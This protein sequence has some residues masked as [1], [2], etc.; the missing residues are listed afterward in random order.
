MIVPTFK[1]RATLLEAVQSV[2]A[3]TWVDLEI[4]V[5]DDACPDDSTQVLT[6]LSDPRIR[7]VR[8][9]RN[10]GLSGARNAGMSVARG[11]FIALLDADDRCSPKRLERQISVLDA[12]PNVGLVTSLANRIDAA[13]QLVSRA[14]DVWRLSEQ[15]LEPLLLFTS[16]L[17]ASSYVLRRSVIPEHGFRPILAED[18]GMTHDVIAMG[19]DV[20]MIREALVDYR[21]SS[22]GIMA[23]KL[24]RVAAGA[25][26]VQ[27]RALAR[28]GI[29]DTVY[30]EALARDIMYFGVTSPKTLTAEWLMRVQRFLDAVKC[31]NE[32]THVHDAEGL[33][34]AS[35]RLWEMLLL[36]AARRGGVRFDLR[37]V[38]LFTSTSLGHLSALRARAV[39]HGLANLVRRR[40]GK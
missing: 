6:S 3:Q 13:G 15:A 2:V 28:V 10:V 39:A 29:D 4:I 27:R 34:E 38:R 1:A 25:L 12:Q 24:D 8:L 5:V 40:P 37:S 19:H 33:A 30:D 23:S 35:G 7:I 11:E 36:E 21:I 18:F 17:T 20:R 22:G 31:A 16:P 14:R 32:K 26:S 9:E